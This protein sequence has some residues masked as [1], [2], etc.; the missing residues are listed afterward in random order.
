MKNRII[1]IFVIFLIGFISA[2]VGNHSL[3]TNILDTCSDGFFYCF[4]TWASNVTTGMYWTF[5]L[6][7]F[8]S[9]LFVATLRFGSPRA[10]GFA[11]FVGLL[12]G[13]W[14][15]TLQLIPWWT[16]STFII[17]GAIGM[18]TLVLNEKG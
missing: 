4:A 17:V 11:S 12:G 1:P 18:V 8:C 3:P 5:A 10:F 9:I 7:T 13:V 6:L 14:L 16:G 2:Q 15:S